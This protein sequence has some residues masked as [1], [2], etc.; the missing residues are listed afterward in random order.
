[1]PRL[2]YWDQEDYDKAIHLI[3]Q[4]RSINLSIA[5]TA[6]NAPLENQRVRVYVARS[7]VEGGDEYHDYLLDKIGKLELILEYNESLIDIELDRQTLPKDCGLNAITFHWFHPGTWF[8]QLS[9]NREL[10]KWA[11]TMHTSSNGD[12]IIDVTYDPALTPASAS[13]GFTQLLGHNYEGPEMGSFAEAS[14]A[15][16]GKGTT[17]FTFHLQT[18]FEKWMNNFATAYKAGDEFPID[19]A[20]IFNTPFEV[21]SSSRKDPDFVPKTYSGR[22]DHTDGNPYLGVPSTTPESTTKVTVKHTLTITE[23]MLPK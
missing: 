1:M 6:N 4:P 11:A 21:K 22:V 10:T 15:I 2:A 8:N 7:M 18:F 9:I 5:F 12:V 23:S 14:V 17:Q 3:Q 16:T 19:L 13:V 20:L